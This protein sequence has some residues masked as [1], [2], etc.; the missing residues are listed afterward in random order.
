MKKLM[1]IVMAFVM[2]QANAQD[3]KKGQQK[4]DKKERMH[5]HMDFT[6]EEMAT[7]QT[8]KMVLRLDLTDAQQKKIYKINLV[9]A[10]ERKVKMEAHKKMKAANKGEKPTKEARFKMMNDRLDK[11]IALKKQMKEILSEEQFKTY[12]KSTKQKHSKQ[13]KQGK[14]RSKKQRSKRSE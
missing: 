12:E 14:H 2:L 10:Q 1:L 11:Q 13:R 6:P 9:N 5:K 3:H 4:H 8:K 7:L